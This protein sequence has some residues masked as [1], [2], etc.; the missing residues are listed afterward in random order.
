VIRLPLFEQLDVDGYGMYPGT[1]T[2]PGLHITFDPGLTLI[3]GVNG[4]G[5]T[6]LVTILYRMCTGPYEISGL[7]SSP[8]LGS[9][10]L[11][12]TKLTRWDQRV[13]ATRVTDEAASASA[14]LRF[15]IGSTTVE[16]TRRL[17]SLAVTRLRVDNV[18]VQATDDMFQEVVKDMCGLSAFGDWI[19]ILRYLV[20]YFEDRR[21]LVWDPSAQAQIL[22]LLLLPTNVASAWAAKERQVLELDSRVR[23]LQNA[24]NREEGVERR[25]RA[26]AKEGEAVAKEL[27]QLDE[28]LRPQVVELETVSQALPGAEEARQQAR[29]RALTF[30]QE[31]DAARRDLEQLQLSRIAAAFPSGDETARYLI[32]RLLS[33]DTCQ[34]CGNVVPEVAASLAERIESSHCVICGSGLDGARR[35]PRGRQGALTRLTAEVERLETARAASTQARG[36]AEATYE[37][38]VGEFTRLDVAVARTRSAIAALVRRLPPDERSLREQST[39]VSSL[40]GRLDRLRLELEGLRSEF[41]ALVRRDMRTIAKHRDSIVAAFREFAE[42]FLF[43]SSELKWAPHKSRVGQTGPLVDFPA[44]EFEMAG[45]DFPSPVRRAGPDQVSESQREFVDL[46]FRMTLMRVA[47]ETGSGSIVIDAPE[48]SLDAVFSERA[49]TVLV[50]FADPTLNNRVVVTS[51]LVDGQL[52]PR[53]LMEAGIDSA[54]DRRFVDLLEM[55]TPTRA[56]VE[57]SREYESVRDRL[58]DESVS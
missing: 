17:S 28:A 44:F 54:S 30:E 33:T 40:R 4:L 27:A 35:S 55:A 48:A 57:L 5:K 50:R 49:A 25:A 13:F 37:D 32:S 7:S 58:F 53:M 8:V 12:A 38:L 24:L 18:E 34:T 29:L 19:L 41:E 26:K 20:F 31:Y 23:N 22:R 21:A 16:V 14:T 45:S 2:R 10:S 11:E 15:T 9:R 46:A 51:N 1:P 39:E 6:T 47:S 43:E 52:I 42:G 3:L 56:V 36:E